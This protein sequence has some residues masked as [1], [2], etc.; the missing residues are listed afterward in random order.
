M[1]PDIEVAAADNKSALQV[2]PNVHNFLTTFEYLAGI[3]WVTY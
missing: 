2:K 1:L 3:L